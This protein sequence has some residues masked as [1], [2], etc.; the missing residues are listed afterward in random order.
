MVRKH[1]LPSTITDYTPFAA[2][3]PGYTGSDIEL[4]VTTAWRFALRDGATALTE[5]T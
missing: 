3:T 4:A 1:K 5:S 2:R